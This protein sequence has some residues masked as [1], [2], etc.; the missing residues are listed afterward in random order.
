M[1]LAIYALV[2]RKCM[3]MALIYRYIHMYQQNRT[4]MDAKSPC[5][6]CDSATKTMYYEKTV[7]RKC[8]VCGWEGYIVKIPEV[9]R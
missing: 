7:A 6:V 5:Y 9:I 1:L 2:Y 8:L 4:N 3:K